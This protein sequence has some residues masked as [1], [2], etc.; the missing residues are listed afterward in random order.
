M[1]KTGCV[2]F[3]DFF[4]KRESARGVAVLDIEFKK[5]Y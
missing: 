1:T 2:K 5:F 3:Q 4:N